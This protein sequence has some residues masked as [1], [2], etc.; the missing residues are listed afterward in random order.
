[1]RFSAKN[2]ELVQAIPGF[3]RGAW[4]CRTP[5]LACFDLATERKQWSR[6]LRS[7]LTG[8]SVALMRLQSH[9]SF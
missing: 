3:G 2:Q 9:E 4:I 1:M 5:D 7:R 8:E 6:A